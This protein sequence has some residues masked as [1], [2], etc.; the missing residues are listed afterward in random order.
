MIE[1]LM[2]FGLTRQEATIYVCLFQNGSLNGYE[3]AKLTGISRSNVYIAL[4]GLVEKGAAYLIEGASAKYVAVDVAE[5]CENKI[6][7]IAEARDYL[8][9]NL[10]PGKEVTD[11]YI[12]I[13]GYANIMDKVYNMLKLAEKRVYISVSAAYI[14]QIETVVEN[15]LSDKKIKVVVITDKDTSFSNAKVYLSDKKEKQLRL[16]VDSK[17]VLT[18]DITESDTDTCLYSGQKNFVNVF[19]EALR[20]E[21]KLIELKKE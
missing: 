16:I 19:K 15:A 18:G 5:F 7:S 12:T 13:E 2:L 3:V 1:K 4:A 8:I 10:E 9:E 14:S 21:I 6:R 17:Y 20:N 11:G